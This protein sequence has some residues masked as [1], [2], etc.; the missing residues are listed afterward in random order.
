MG[1]YRWRWDADNWPDQRINWNAMSRSQKSYTIKEYNKA[2]ARRNLGPIPNPFNKAENN[3]HNTIIKNPDGSETV[4]PRTEGRP[5]ISPLSTAP[6]PPAQRGHGP[7]ID[8]FAQ[9]QIQVDR[10]EIQRLEKFFNSAEGQRIID[11]IAEQN[12]NAESDEFSG[13]QAPHRP[14]TADNNEP[15]PGPSSASDEPASKRARID[16]GPSHH[17]EGGAHEQADAMPIPGSAMETEDQ[18]TGQAGSTAQAA[19]GGGRGFS[20]GFASATG[21][22]VYVKQPKNHANPSKFKFEKTHRILGYGLAC[23]NLAHENS[24]ASASMR[25]MTT[26]LQEIPVDR[27]FFYLNPG[28]WESLQQVPGA[29]ITHVKVTVVQ[30]NPRVAFETGSS[31][32]SLATLNQNKFG[33]KAVGLNSIAGLRVTSRRLS[34]FD[35]AGEPMIPT[36]STAAVYSDIDEAMYGKRQTDTAFNTARPAEPF[37]IPM[38]I[39]NYLCCWNHGYDTTSAQRTA[40]GWY[41]L[42]EHVV[43]FDMQATAGKVIEVYEYS[44]SYAPVSEQL[45]YCEYLNGTQANVNASIF[46]YNDGDA[47][48]QMTRININNMTPVTNA[49]PT[50]SIAFSNTTLNGF[51]AQVIDRL[52]LL[53]KG[54]LLKNIDSGSRNKCVQPSLHVGISPV[55]RLTSAA[56]TIL[57]NSWTDVQ[58]YYEIHAECWI[59]AYSPH[60]NTHQSQFHVETHDI[61]MGVANSTISSNYP[62]RFG[63]YPQTFPALNRNEEN[64]SSSIR[65]PRDASS[66]DTNAP[67]PKRR[68][69]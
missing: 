6:D 10:D 16:E 53:E 26:S 69:F 1:K 7:I 34:A 39:P 28:E 25:L 33:I 3:T 2:R 64:E 29:H 68:I 18:T 5:R 45:P 4:T 59:E 9:Q 14:I 43:Q 12:N 60:H 44:P 54:Q 17:T 38:T 47:T 31:T 41:S 51:D 40:N 8:A 23:A 15:Q 63:K 61:K 56:N 49:N 46:N 66:E 55:P 36:A 24:T 50:E 52:A 48:K 62:V 20:G 27:P 37:M 65:K 58:S 32:T 30:R 35:Q 13:G 67:Q 22:E 21:P 19:A 11:E 57:P 42:S